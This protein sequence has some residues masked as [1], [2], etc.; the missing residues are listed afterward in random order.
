[1][2]FEELI[3][4]ILAKMPDLNKWK[5]D[6]LAHNF[7]LQCQLRG[8]HNFLNMSRY[9]GKNESTYRNNYSFDFD[10]S[11]FNISLIKKY[12]SE[13]CAVAFDPSY[14]RKSGKDTPGSGYFWS[15]CLNRSVWGLEIGGF[16]AVDIDQNTALHYRA[17]QTFFDKEQY[18]SLLEYYACLVVSRV[19]EIL[20]ISK[21]LVVDAFFSREPFV[22][23]VYDAGLEIISRLRDDADLLYP[24]VGPHPK[25]RGPKTKWAGKFD[26]KNLN[27]AY[28]APCLVQQ[29]NEKQENYELHEGVVYSKALKRFI[30]LVVQY[31]LDDQG[32]MKS[33]KLFCSTDLQLSGVQIFLL[34]KMRFQI[35]LLYRDAKQ[36]TG[37]EH[38]QSRKEDKLDFHFNTALTTVSL[39]KAAFHL[40][41][42]ME[43]RK[44]F[45]MRD[46][47]TQMF[48]D[49]MMDI[50]I[51]ECGIAPNCPI[52]QKARKRVTSLGRIY[53]MVA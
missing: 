26:P 4:T 31:K 10:F 44:P 51:K 40:N 29:D 6:F 38:C 23:K 15:G 52:I 49:L 46:I 2:S 9:G 14:I 35:E 30:K 5:R 13:D 47:K 1:M 34:Y 28:F 33:Y 21:Y 39:A 43:E 11:S 36:F 27:E 42:P 19:A 22:S 17:D 48:N 8:R 45:S 32:E 12:F 20:Q 7:K 16:A 18:G 24:Y 25:R 53:P 41:K 37:L 3:D 50:I